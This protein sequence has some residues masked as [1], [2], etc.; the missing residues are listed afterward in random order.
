MARQGIK[1]TPVAVNRAVCEVRLCQRRALVD[2]ENLTIGDLTANFNPETLEIRIMK[3]DN[4]HQKDDDCGSP[5][6]YPKTA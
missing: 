4:F 5:E 2:D 6:G 1:P 3:V